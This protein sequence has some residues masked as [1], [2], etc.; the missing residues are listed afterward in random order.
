MRLASLIIHDVD[1]ATWLVLE[2]MNALGIVKVR[3]YRDKVEDTPCL[4]VVDVRLKD[5]LLDK[6]LQMLIGKVDAE[7]VK[8]VGMACHV[9]G[10]GG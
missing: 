10:P 4:A 3:H 2:K 9:L 5:M 6:V 8:G 7:L 1:E